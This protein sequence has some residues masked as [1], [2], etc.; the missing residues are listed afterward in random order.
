M[1]YLLGLVDM[2]M[3][4]RLLLYYWH[5]IACRNEYLKQKVWMIFNDKEHCEA[6]KYNF[7]A[8]F[9]EGTFGQKVHFR[10]KEVG[11]CQGINEFLTKTLW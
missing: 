6:L 8:E 7:T 5:E 10:D 4:I 11:E 9:P 2:M 3:A 1:I